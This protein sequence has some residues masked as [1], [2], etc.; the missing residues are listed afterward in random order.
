[1]PDVKGRKATEAARQERPQW[2]ESG[3]SRSVALD[4]QWLGALREKSVKPLAEFTKRSLIE[5]SELHALLDDQSR[6]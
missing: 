3:H 4:G 1:M 5:K 2:V 6:P